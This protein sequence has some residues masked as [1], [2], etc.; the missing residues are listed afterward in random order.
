MIVAPSPAKR[1]YADADYSNRVDRAPPR[2]EIPERQGGEVKRLDGRVLRRMRRLG[3]VRQVLPEV[4][5]VYA[6]ATEKRGGAPASYMNAAA[7][8]RSARCR[9]GQSR[10]ARSMAAESRR[11]MAAARKW[12]SP[13]QCETQGTATGKG[14]W[15][16]RGPNVAR[17]SAVE[18]VFRDHSGAQPEPSTSHQLPEIR[19]LIG[20][21]SASL[22]RNVTKRKDLP[23]STDR[24]SPRLQW[25]SFTKKTA[26]SKSR[27]MMSRISRHVDATEIR[28]SR[29]SQ[30]ASTNL[31]RAI[32]AFESAL[33]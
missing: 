4:R 6:V 27:T 8:D 2:K 10:R 5:C 26:A 24:H 17:P 15:A 9:A 21:G 14:V 33:S 30:R 23:S 19:Q 1:H 18:G 16:I 11:W 29:Q 12:R 13:A 7:A 31:R 22:P 28:L 20:L 25:A 32:G 3:V